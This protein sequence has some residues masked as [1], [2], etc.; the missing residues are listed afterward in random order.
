[1]WCC[2]GSAGLPSSPISHCDTLC[3]KRGARRH[4]V[5]IEQ[6]S[7]P[8]VGRRALAIEPHL[9][10]QC[11]IRKRNEVDV[12]ADRLT[13]VVRDEAAV[14]AELYLPT[15]EGG[16]RDFVQVGLLARTRVRH[17]NGVAFAGA[18]TWPVSRSISSCGCFAAGWGATAFR[19]SANRAS[20]SRSACSFCS[21]RTCADVGICFR[22]GLV[23][24]LCL[25]D[26]RVHWLAVRGGRYPLWFASAGWT[27]LEIVF[28]GQ[29]ALL[30]L[31]DSRSR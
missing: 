16:R 17:R 30:R 4:D 31:L 1:M 22:T 25:F 18:T 28:A 13:V 8:A 3:A 27:I 12:V 9:A 26:C 20:R 23:M 10:D 2:Q 5:A 7:H 15:N 19:P 24:M 21:F 11:L 29:R 14:L 6:Q